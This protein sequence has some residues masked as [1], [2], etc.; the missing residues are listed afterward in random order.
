VITTIHRTTFGISGVICHNT[1]RPV[2][3]HPRRIMSLKPAN[4]T[5]PAANPRSPPLTTE[6]CQGSHPGR[7]ALKQKSA[8][9]HSRPRRPKEALPRRQIYVESA[10]NLT[11]AN[12]SMSIS[13]SRRFWSSPKK[14]HRRPIWTMPRG[15]ISTDQGRGRGRVHVNARNTHPRDRTVWR[16]KRQPVLSRFPSSTHRHPG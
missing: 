13:S 14:R 6:N 2:M 1:I 9:R 16:N 15:L 5:V 3:R 4:S 11:A 7:P 12:R 10:S 8:R